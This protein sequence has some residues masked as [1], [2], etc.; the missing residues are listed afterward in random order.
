MILLPKYGV[1]AFTNTLIEEIVDDGVIVRL[2]E[3]KTLKVG[4]DTVILALGFTPNNN[5]YEAL[6]GKI[7]RLYRIGDCVKARAIVDAVHE[8]ACI[9]RII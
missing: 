4:A 1:Q 9:A 7:P 5:L 3:G 6:K 8:G 2:P